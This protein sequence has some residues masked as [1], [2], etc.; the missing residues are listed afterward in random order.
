MG[1]VGASHNFVVGEIMN[2]KAN[3]FDIRDRARLGQGHGS[4][5]TFVLFAAFV[6][7]TMM[8]SPARLCFPSKKVS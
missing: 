5:Q 3:K 2:K 7:V 8:L 1:G 6:K 4:N